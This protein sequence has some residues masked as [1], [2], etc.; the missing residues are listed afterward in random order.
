VRRRHGR[1]HPD[2][3]RGGVDGAELLGLVREEADAS[4]AADLVLAEARPVLRWVEPALELED[5]GL[6]LQEISTN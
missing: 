5:A 6:Q 2:G 4:R 3:D 1:L